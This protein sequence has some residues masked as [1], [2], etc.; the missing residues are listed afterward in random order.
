MGAHS[1]FRS[2]V[3]YV[4]KST[5]HTHDDTSS[6]H[7]VQRSS[8]RAPSLGPPVGAESGRAGSIGAATIT[9]RLLAITTASVYSFFYF[10]FFNV[11]NLTINIDNLSV[12]MPYE[13]ARIHS[14]SRTTACLVTHLALH[15]PESSVIAVLPF[16]W[17]SNQLARALTLHSCHNSLSSRSSFDSM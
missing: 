3:C 11:R 6:P 15:S 12:I 2:T 9:T 8:R 10:F 16:L 14:S 1:V 5:H 13:C 17:A 7:T 4:P